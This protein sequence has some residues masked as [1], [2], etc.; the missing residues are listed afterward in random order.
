MRSVLF[1]LSL[2]ASIP[3]LAT[4][5]VVLSALQPKAGNYQLFANDAAHPCGRGHLDAS[6]PL[7]VRV[8]VPE[9]DSEFEEKGD[10]MLQFE[11]YG[12]GSGTWYS[13]FEQPAFF[14]IN[15]WAKRYFMPAMGAWI[16]HKSTFDP[17][18]GTLV[19]S[20]AIS[21]LTGSEAGLQTVVF[22]GDAV[23]YT[24][25]IVDYNALGRETKRE[26]AAHCEL[27]RRE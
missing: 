11:Q 19:H 14:R 16:T 23:S 18:T 12:S 25:E 10:V 27:A 22:H 2:F 5:Q 26:L 24:Y 21:T 7:R 17:I 15:G 8:W 1:A 6:T 4:D 20:A 9:A 13:A 3:A